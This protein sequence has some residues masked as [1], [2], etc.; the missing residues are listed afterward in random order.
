MPSKY[1]GGYTIIDLGGVEIDSTPK[2]VPGVYEKILHA[3]QPVV[4]SNFDYS[5]IPYAPLIASGVDSN[6][7]NSV[8][9]G[10]PYVDLTDGDMLISSAIVVTE[11][12]E[13]YYIDA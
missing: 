3:K 7:D 6:G 13:V 5:N 9:F 10:I 12:D 11:N 1:P 4:L 8:F 2:E